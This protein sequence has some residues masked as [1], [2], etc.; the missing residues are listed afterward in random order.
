[1]DPVNPNLELEIFAR[2]HLLLY[3]VTPHRY[4]CVRD[5]RAYLESICDLDVQTPCEHRQI[6][7]T[8]LPLTCVPSLNSVFTFFYRI[9]HP[10]HN[11]QKHQR[12]Q[13][14]PGSPHLAA[15]FYCIFR[16]YIYHQYYHF[17]SI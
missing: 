5:A 8:L 4:A 17:H 2:K 12:I 6:L 11:I 1:M 14:E 9:Y 7:P 10:N 13:E 3:D 16:G 15:E